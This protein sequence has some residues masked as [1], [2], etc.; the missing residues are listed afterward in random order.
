MANVV[1]PYKFYKKSICGHLDPATTLVDIEESHTNGVYQQ[2][3]RDSRGST[4]GANRAIAPPQLPYSSH[5]MRD[6]KAYL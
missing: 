3:S 4:V 5:K 6:F 1:L 2:S